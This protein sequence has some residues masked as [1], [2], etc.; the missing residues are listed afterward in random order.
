MTPFLTRNDSNQRTACAR[1]VR[2]SPHV[3]CP[4]YKSTEYQV[5]VSSLQ[6]CHAAVLF[7]A[8]EPKQLRQNRQV[9][10]GNC[11]SEDLQ[12]GS[13]PSARAWYL[14]KIQEQCRII[15]LM[16]GRSVSSLPP[17]LIS[18]ACF[19]VRNISPRVQFALSM[20]PMVA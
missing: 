4:V 11:C 1:S 7:R 19:V 5:P 13:L 15:Q 9:H 16:R 12:K 14:Q 8:P 18:V 2:V 10:L 6:T 17:T 3:C 20:A